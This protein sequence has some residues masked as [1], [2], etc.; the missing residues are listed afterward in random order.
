MHPGDLST[1]NEAE[2]ASLRHW[3][4]RWQTAREMRDYTT[5]DAIRE[6]LH[7][8]GVELSDHTWHAVRESAASRQTRWQLRQAT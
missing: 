3:Y 7:D 2:Q 5:A 1:L 4:D 8:A 6:R